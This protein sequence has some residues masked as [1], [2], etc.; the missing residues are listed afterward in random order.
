[1]TNVMMRFKKNRKGFTLIELIVVIAI[2]AILA[3]ILVPR[4]TGFTDTARTRAMNSEMK[5]IVSAVEAN[6]ADTGSWPQ[7]STDLI[8]HGNIQTIFGKTLD[9]TISRSE[10]GGTLTGFTYTKTFSGGSSQSR[11]FT[12]ATGVIN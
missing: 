11:T 8:L 4:F 10:T 12:Y 2:I 5:G 1:M 9:G 7:G 3:L 6:Y